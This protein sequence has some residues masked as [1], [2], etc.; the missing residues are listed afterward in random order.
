MARGYG[1]QE[2][3]WVDAKGFEGLYQVSNL[4]R[5]KALE[6]TWHTGMHYTIRHKKE[7]IMKTRK[8]RGGYE[9]VILRCKNKNKTITIHRLVLMSFIENKHNH[10]YINHKNGIKT[11]NN[12]DN[13]EWCTAKENVQHAIKLGLRKGYVTQT[14]RHTRSKLTDA[15]AAEIRESTLSLTE[16]S[17][18]YHVNQASIYYIKKGRTYKQLKVV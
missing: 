16:L 14:K 4:G 8:N 11:D 1:N 2:E 15:Q 10:P 3:M 6:K 9:Y 18:R 7:H 12:I 5:V 13:L 17:Y